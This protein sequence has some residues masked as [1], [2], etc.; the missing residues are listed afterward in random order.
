MCDHYFSESRLA[1]VILSYQLPI[2]IRMDWETYNQ[3]MGDNKLV[4]FMVCYGDAFPLKDADGNEVLGGRRSSSDSIKPSWG[5]RHTPY[6]SETSSSLSSD[7]VSGWNQIL[8]GAVHPKKIKLRS[9]IQF[10]K[11][12]I[13]AM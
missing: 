9:K 11:L 12:L 6:L 8:K 3:E 5:W 13:E 2:D 1:A 4:D 10:G 7:N